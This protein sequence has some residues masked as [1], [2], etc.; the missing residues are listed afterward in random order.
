MPLVC[1]NRPNRSVARFFSAKDAARIICAA[2]SHGATD[3]EISKA[4]FAKC[5][6]DPCNKEKIREEIESLQKDIAE[7]EASIEIALVV[8]AVI[9]VAFGRIK[10]IPIVKRLLPKTEINF[11]R[12]QATRAL[13]ANLQRTSKRLAELAAKENTGGGGGR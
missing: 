2:K 7:L 13:I 6:F 1:F 5:G 9:A 3:V 8:M 10:R 12:V 4:A 11:A